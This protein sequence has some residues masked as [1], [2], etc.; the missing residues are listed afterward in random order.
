MNQIFYDKL[1][2]CYESIRSLP[3][4]QTAEGNSKLKKVKKTILRLHNVIKRDGLFALDEEKIDLDWNYDKYY[5]DIREMVVCGTPP[6]TVEEVAMIQFASLGLSGY[7]G[8]AYLMFLKGF[9]M[10]ED[11]CSEGIIETELSA[12]FTVKEPDYRDGRKALKR[13]QERK[14]TPNEAAYT[15]DIKILEETV[16]RMREGHIKRVLEELEDATIAKILLGMQQTNAIEIFIRCLPTDRMLGI[17]RILDAH[18]DASMT[19]TLKEIDE[20]CD[21]FLKVEGYSY[22]EGVLRCGWF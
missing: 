4:E 10:I 19:A 13:L 11:S 20:A 3:V 7:D 14:T 18:L 17:G 2:E 16:E 5:E 9:L 6:D 15:F 1:S 21:E 8:V 12:F 22:I